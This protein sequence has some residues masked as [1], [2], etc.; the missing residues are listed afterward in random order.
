M[1]RGLDLFSGI[2]GVTHGLRGIV[3]PVS[4]CEKNAGAR[5]FLKRAHPD[6]EVF[7]DVCTLDATGMKGEIDIITG[8]WPCTGFSTAGKGAGFEH[9]ASGLFTE[10]IRIAKECDPTYLFLENSHVLSRTE[11]I[12]VVVKALHEI[13]YDCR[14]T[15]CHA[16]AVGARHGRYRWFC[17]ATKRGGETNMDIPAIEKF[18]WNSAEPPRQTETRSAENKNRLGFLGNAVV[19]DQV[20]Y[21]FEILT[22]LKPADHKYK[23]NADNGFSEGGVMTT[24]SIEHPTAEPI[25][26]VIGPRPDEASF[27]I[28]CDISKVMTKPKIVRYW[29]TPTYSLRT[30]YKSPRTLTNR[31][32]TMLCAQVSF[33]EGGVHGHYINSDWVRWL[34]GFPANY[35]DV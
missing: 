24:F 13:G 23:K 11:N 12:S 14:W 9:D 10:I 34:M 35:F 3:E 26:I 31:V 17:L 32:S 27:A 16:T 20:R 28:R 25:N 21:A 4:Y 15:T 6:V 18:D 2:G 30:A 7:E 29:A 8:G 5:A 33:C 19:P 22:T 1:L